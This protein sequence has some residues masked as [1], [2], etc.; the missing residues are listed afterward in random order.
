MEPYKTLLVEDRGPVRLITLNQPAIFNPLDEVSGPELVAALE[1]ADL[2]PAVRALVLT[3]AGKAF[4]AGGNVRLMG[5]QL[6]RGEATARFFAAIG[7]VLNRSIIALRRLRKPVVCA[8]NGVAAGGGLGWCL[9]CDLVVA[10][11]GAR[12]DPGYIRIALNPDGGVTAIITRLVGHKRATEFFLLGQAL[13]AE[14][15]LAWGLVNRVVDDGVVLEEALKLAGQLAQGPRQAL[16]AS[17]DLLNR[18]VFGDLENILENERGYL[19]QLAD[20]PDFVEGIKAFFE[21][22]KPTFNG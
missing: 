2:D 20:R 3:G 21:R 12:L 8:L 16:A 17:K 9:A 19:L 11:K 7:G 4:S 13:D 15:A 14:T 10:A 6:Q 1:A 18:A 22:R 5:E